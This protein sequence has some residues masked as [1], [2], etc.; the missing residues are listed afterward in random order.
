[1]SDSK[2]RVRCPTCTR[3][4]RIPSKISAK[5]IV[6]PKCNAKFKVDD[7]GRAVNLAGHND[8]FGP[9]VNVE[10]LIEEPPRETGLNATAFDD[11]DH[12]IQGNP[13]S[14][15]YSGQIQS[16]VMAAVA[17]SPTPT[18]PASSRRRLEVVVP[19][20]RPKSGL[21]K[22][23]RPKRPTKATSP[24]ARFDDSRHRSGRAAIC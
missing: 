4:L 8:W 6:C 7:Q 24:G 3:R 12:L 17:Q 13:A 19:R 22:K 10:E 9:P 2:V 5:T 18:P 21:K 23:T 16:D 1:M 14:S 20:P 11:I 15:S